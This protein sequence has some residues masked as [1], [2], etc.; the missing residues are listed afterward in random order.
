MSVA[1]I[2]NWSVAL[3]P[4]LIM[5]VLF[6]WS[7]FYSPTKPPE[8]TNTTEIANANTTQPTPVAPAEPQPQQ[9]VQT[10]PDATPNRTITIKSPLYEV[11]LD[12]KGGVSRMGR[13]SLCGGTLGPGNDRVGG[14]ARPAGPAGSRLGAG[15]AE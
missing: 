10:T 11:T 13:S 1:E 7:Y 5:V 12:S 14:R 9:P 2:F 8:N 3:V 15:G 6:A 4:V